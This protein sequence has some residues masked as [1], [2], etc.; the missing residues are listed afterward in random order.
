MI[1][2]IKRGK[3]ITIIEALKINI[4][5][6]HQLVQRNLIM[7][8]SISR[9]RTNSQKSRSRIRTTGCQSLVLKCIL[10]FVKMVYGQ[11]RVV[12]DDHVYAVVSE[13]RQGNEEGTSWLEGDTWRGDGWLCYLRLSQ[14]KSCEK[15]SAARERHATFNGTFHCITSQGNL[16][17]K[18]DIK[19]RKVI[20]I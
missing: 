6:N 19:R 3:Y 10:S 5:S 13:E 20:P 1:C 12:D 16:I 18:I 7:H 11:T 9:W 15:C 4:Q 8:G 14:R 2:I 17:Y